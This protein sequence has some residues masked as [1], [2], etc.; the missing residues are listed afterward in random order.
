MTLENLGEF[1]PDAFV[2]K[3]R[4]SAIKKCS[5]LGVSGYGTPTSVE[6]F[7][8]AAAGPK[9]DLYAYFYSDANELDLGPALTL[10]N[11]FAG[12]FLSMTAVLKMD[13]K[14]LEIVES[15]QSVYGNSG[16][17]A[18]D[19]YGYT[20]LSGPSLLSGSDTGS[21]TIC[22]EIFLLPPNTHGVLQ[23]K[24]SSLD[25]LE[26]KCRVGKGCNSK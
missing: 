21:R 20:Y 6:D 18:V 15:I 19:K 7:I 4:P 9:G 26:A 22:N 24:L 23:M 13:R 2:L 25:C 11:D 5:V 3:L 12:E 16:S 1:N 14:T 17:L 10:R 8:S